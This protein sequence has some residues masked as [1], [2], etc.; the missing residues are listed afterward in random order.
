MITPK[1]TTVKS[2]M[3]KIA[4]MGVLPAHSE[5]F[6]RKIKLTNLICVSLALITFPYALIFALVGAN[7]LALLIF[8]IAS[9]Y[10]LL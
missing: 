9:I 6:S 5:Q 10:A 3:L 4:G 2:L 8:P 7:T 1:K